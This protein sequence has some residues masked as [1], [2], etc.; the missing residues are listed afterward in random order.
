LLT[1]G[2]LGLE[3]LPWKTLQRQQDYYFVG[4]DNKPQRDGNICVLPEKQREYCDLVRAADVIIAKP[5]Y[6]IV[7]DILAHQTPVLYVERNDFPEFAYLA[8]ALNELTTAEFLPLDDLLSGSIEQHL[9]RLLQQE[10]H[11]AAVPLNGAQVA[12]EKIIALAVAA[13]S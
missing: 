11:W 6:G 4:T 7:A 8:Q 2:G 10:R 12:A 13:S 3:R 9:V 5:G 1:F